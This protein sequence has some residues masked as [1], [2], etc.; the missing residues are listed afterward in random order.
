[1]HNF[2]PVNTSRLI[3]TNLGGGVPA[4]VLIGPW[5]ELESKRES[6]FARSEEDRERAKKHTINRDTNPYFACGEESGE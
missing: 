1:M 3:G 5:I 4:A 6:N 2:E